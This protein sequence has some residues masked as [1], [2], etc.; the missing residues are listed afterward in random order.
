[1]SASPI[2]HGRGHADTFATLND[3]ELFRDGHDAALDGTDCGLQSPLDSR[4]CS[5]AARHAGLTEDRYAGQPAFL[6]GKVT[7]E[8]HG[9]SSRTSVESPQCESI[10]SAPLNLPG[11]S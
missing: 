4:F 8:W 10:S 6:R 1:M 2:L 3:R 5:G 7:D 9:G 11:R